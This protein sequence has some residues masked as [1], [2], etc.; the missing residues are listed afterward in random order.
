M[1]PVYVLDW[2]FVEMLHLA[3]Y[4]FVCLKA[5]GNNHCLYTREHASHCY[6]RERWEQAVL[7]AS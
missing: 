5:K 6:V 2:I 1:L 3:T 7:S 4:L